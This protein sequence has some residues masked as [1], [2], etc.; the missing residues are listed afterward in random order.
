MIKGAL[1]VG[2][3]VSLLKEMQSNENVAVMLVDQADVNTWN[4]SPAGQFVQMDLGSFVD[5]MSEGSAAWIDEDI[6][7]E[8]IQ[9]VLRW[10]PHA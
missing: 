10:S 1:K 3:V 4:T 7:Q 5:A 6:T 9:D 8:D 2:E